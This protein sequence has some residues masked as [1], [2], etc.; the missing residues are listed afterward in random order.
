MQRLRDAGWVN[1]TALP[2]SP[3]TIAKLVSKGWI[4]MLQ[5]PSGT[6]YRLTDTGLQ[7]KK[8]PVKTR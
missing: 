3:K 6:A 1:A 5:T 7:A 4:E 8:A 2:N